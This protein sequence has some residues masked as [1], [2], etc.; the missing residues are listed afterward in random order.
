MSFEY[1][2]RTKI[3]YGENSH[4]QLGQYILEK[5][6]NPH[7]T[8]VTDKGIVSVGISEYIEKVLKTAHIDYSLYDGVRPD[9]SAAQIDE[10]AQLI[11]QNN[12]NVVI[13]L[14][15]G[16]AMDVAK[17][18]ALVASDTYNAMHYALMVNP[19][20]TSDKLT[21]AIPTTAGTGAEV[22]STV[23]FSTPEGR[24]V[25]GWDE[26][27]APNIAILDPLF[28]VNLPLSIT[29]PTT[30]DAFIHAMEAVSGRR[31]NPF[32]EAV[33]LKAIQLI[34]E[35]FEQLLENPKDIETRGKIALGATLAGLAIEQGGTGLG[36]CIGHALGT[37]AKVP[38]GQ[39]VAISLYHCIEWLVTT[40]PQSYVAIQKAL[41]VNTIEEIAKRY[42]QMVEKGHLSL[43]IN[44]LTEQDIEQFVSIMQAEENQPMLQNSCALPSKD[45]LQ[46]F[47]KRII[48]GS[49]P[50]LGVDI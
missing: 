2:S 27:M 1:F 19:F 12:S 44:S 21:I 37:L 35:N 47:A 29:V 36:H 38:H 49:M 43:T 17:M 28:T 34:N 11:R 16:S 22:T 23:V 41:N 26:Q 50:K 18:A 5:Q 9:P 40:T 45:D 8:I 42:Q 3:I 46:H 10:V 7:V 14:G 24:K 13:G 4:Q 25:W 20:S 48:L 33:G 15:G 31:T 30:L 32:I 6:A 39:A